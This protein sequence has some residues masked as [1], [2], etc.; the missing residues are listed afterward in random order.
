MRAKQYLALCRLYSVR[1]NIP[2]VLRTADILIKKLR[3]LAINND[4]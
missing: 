1:H 4:R 3:R 2:A